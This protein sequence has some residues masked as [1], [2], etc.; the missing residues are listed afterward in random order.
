MAKARIAI[1]EDD[2]VIAAAMT[3]AFERSGYEVFWTN[4]TTEMNEYLGKFTVATLF[5]D[6]L[7]PGGSGVD[8]V[9]SIRKKFPA[10]VL[11][12]VIMSGIFTDAGFIKE[13]TRA[14]RAI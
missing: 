5:V 6:C 4:Q 8:F 9:T 3:A 2:N 7:L 1:L 11:D 14:T 12:V 13:T 10:N